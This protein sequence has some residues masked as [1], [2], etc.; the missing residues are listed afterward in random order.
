VSAKDRFS[1]LEFALVIGTAFGWSILFSVYALILGTTVGESASQQ[2]FGNA[3]LLGVVVQEALL[4][5]VPLA[6]LYARGW[7]VADFRLGASISATAAG[8]AIYVA[9]LVADWLINLL[10]QAAFPVAES[11]LEALGAYRPATGPTLATVVLVSLVNPV[12]EE[13]FVCAYVVEA[14][15]PRF[16]ATTA[17]NVSVVIRASYHLYQG[18]PAFPFHCAYGL[19]Q[20]Y[21]YAR[22]G[23]LWPL[24]VSHAL[25]DFAAF[26]QLT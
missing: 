2:A 7:R 6:V 22:Y 15:R 13:V 1:P 21:V 17:I 5:P 4:A 26:V 24:I 11:A 16:G 10:L 25:L 18:I 9:A 23:R 14:L 20:G 8:F 19:L 3:H 12:F